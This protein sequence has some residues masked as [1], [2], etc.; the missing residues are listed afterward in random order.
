MLSTMTGRDWPQNQRMWTRILH[1]V[2]QSP[3][4]IH[5]NQVIFVTLKRGGERLD[6]RCRRSSLPA[7]C[8]PP[9]ASG[10]GMTPPSRAHCLCR[11]RCGWR[12]ASGSP[13]F[14]RPSTMSPLWSQWRYKR[15]DSLIVGNRP[16][17]GL[18]SPPIPWA[19]TPTCW[20]RRF[21]APTG[22]GRR[23]P[24]RGVHPTGRPVPATGRSFGDQAD[25]GG[26]PYP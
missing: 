15:R 10:F 19:A 20:P 21:C 13:R 11:G 26:W 23:P 12:G 2:R 25:R 17:C 24:S 9:S 16:P 22:G 7:R 6:S 8:W 18:R 3:S 1:I 14:R 4:T 5:P